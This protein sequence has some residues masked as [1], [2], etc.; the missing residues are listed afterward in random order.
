MIGYIARRLLMA[1]FT[2]WAVTVLTFIIIQL[3]PGDY[4]SAHIAELQ[5]QGEA[6]DA[7]KIEALRCDG[8][9]WFSVEV[10]PSPTART[11]SESSGASSHRQTTAPSG[12]NARSRTPP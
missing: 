10:P 8:R 7:G 2:V 3:P 9:D 11:A 5:S 6:V 12:L 1:F 4:L